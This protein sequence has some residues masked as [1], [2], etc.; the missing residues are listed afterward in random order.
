MNLN[1]F[2]WFFFLSEKGRVTG[3]FFLKINKML[4]DKKKFKGKFK[5]FLKNEKQTKQHKCNNPAFD[6]YQYI[7]LRSPLLKKKCNN[8]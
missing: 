3:N 4:N 7:I 8:Y 6:F 5:F 1:I 2:H